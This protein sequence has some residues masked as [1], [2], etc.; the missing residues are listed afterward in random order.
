MRFF[1][2][3]L[4]VN[5]PSKLVSSSRLDGLGAETRQQTSMP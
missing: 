4:E 1:N 3:F 2:I 5:T